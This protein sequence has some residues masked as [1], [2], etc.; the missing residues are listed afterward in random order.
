MMTARW[1][2]ALDKGLMTLVLAIDI[3]A[4]FD[5]VWHDGGCEE[6]GTA[7]RKKKRC[8]PCRWAARVTGPPLLVGRPGKWAA[9]AGEPPV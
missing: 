2:K 5:R 8:R 3:E 4:A 1:A 6:R 9:R 7:E